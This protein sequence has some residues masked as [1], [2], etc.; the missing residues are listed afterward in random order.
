M[1]FLFFP[2]YKLFY[3]SPKFPLTVHSSLRK[4]CL[5]GSSCRVLPL[6]P[7]LLPVLGYCLRKILD[8]LRGRKI[9]RIPGGQLVQSRT[10][11]KDG[12]EDEADALGKA[13][14][15]LERRVISL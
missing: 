6:G 12:R 2:W 14:L 7:A 5:T 13:F 11:R 1:K 3:L 9:G 8:A 4:R 15:T 10:G